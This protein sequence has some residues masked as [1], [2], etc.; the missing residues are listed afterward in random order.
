MALTQRRIT[1]TQA[2][3]HV[4]YDAQ[5]RVDKRVA[6]ILARGEAARHGRAAAAPRPRDPADRPTR[7]ER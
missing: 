3:G 1:R 6:R 4:S 2:T 7:R 5:V